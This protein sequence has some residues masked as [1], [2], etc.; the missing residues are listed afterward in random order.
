MVKSV[1]LAVSVAYPQDEGH[2]SGCVVVLTSGAVA[3][4]HSSG[5][6]AFARVVNTSL[7][8]W[9]RFPVNTLGRIAS[10]VVVCVGTFH[11]VRGVSRLLATVLMCVSSQLLG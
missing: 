8:R 11:F 2:A 7:L 4:L 5:S 1:V 3:E 10:H 6:V 9:W